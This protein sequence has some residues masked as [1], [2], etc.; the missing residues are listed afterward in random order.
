MNPSPTQMY[1]LLNVLHGFLLPGFPILV[2]L[3]T[4]IRLLALF[5]LPSLLPYVQPKTFLPPQSL[6]MIFVISD[7]LL[8]SGMLLKSGPANHTCLLVLM[9]LTCTHLIALAK[10]YH[11]VHLVPSR[12]ALLVRPILSQ[13]TSSTTCTCSSNRT[14]ATASKQMAGGT[15]MC[16]LNRRFRWIKTRLR[17]SLESSA[18]CFCNCSVL[19]IRRWAVR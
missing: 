14:S 7:F 2:I 17:L 19:P 12:P 8:P 4:N 15:G 18:C 3:F 1:L 11:K 6:L 9:Q 5:L 13:S 16:S 10:V